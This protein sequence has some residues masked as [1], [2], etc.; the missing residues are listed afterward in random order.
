[1]RWREKE[2]EGMDEAEIKKTLGIVK[3]A[4]NLGFAH[5]YTSALCVC[6]LN[7]CITVEFFLQLKKSEKLRNLC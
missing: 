1:M 3:N 4:I 7:I 6:L 5:L 2:R